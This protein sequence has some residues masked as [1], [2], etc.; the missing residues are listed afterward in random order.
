MNNGAQQQGDLCVHR[1]RV[2][3][4]FHCKNFLKEDV[5]LWEISSQAKDGPAW[6][7]TAWMCQGVRKALQGDK[8]LGKHCPLRLPR[9]VSPHP[10]LPRQCHPHRLGLPQEPG[11]AS[12]GG[13]L[14]RQISD[15]P[16]ILG[17]CMLTL[18]LLAP[19]AALRATACR[20]TLHRPTSSSGFHG[21]F[22][23]P[24]FQVLALNS[25]TSEQAAF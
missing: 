21:L 19:G 22:A 2:S 14:P 13:C 23:H 1:R 17:A 12:H 5:P 8:A 6:G 11:K 15:S 18:A 9:P 24:C 16:G 4:I 10:H 20:A 3:S 25:Q 7:R